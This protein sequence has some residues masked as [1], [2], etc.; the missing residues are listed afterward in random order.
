MKPIY[1][2]FLLLLS[3][4]IKA[5]TGE[6]R[7]EIAVGVNGG[8]VFNTV[9]FDPTIKQTQHIGPSIGAT[10][11][12]T[13]EKYFKTYCSLQVELNLSQLGWKE[14]VLDHQ[15][16]EL[17]DTYER[18]L[19]YVQMPF[20]ARLAWGKERKGIMGYFLAGPQIGYLLKEKS[21]RS[22]IW[23]LTPD[24]FPDRPN[25]MY[26]HYDLSVQNKLDYG[27]TAGL[28]LEINTGI[29]HFMLDG[30]YYYG[31]SDIFNNSKKDIFGR[32]NHSSIMVKLS[33]LFNIRN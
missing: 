12:I 21:K 20:L 14:V 8:I 27:I 4:T 30:R 9:M 6:P 11:R 31:L 7:S 22:D 16:V 33:Y 32:S 24:G 13:S 28:G 23:T 15:S 26:Q 25:F 18:Q 29:G 3:T 17:P 10:F 5:Q 2:V 19:Y 1:I